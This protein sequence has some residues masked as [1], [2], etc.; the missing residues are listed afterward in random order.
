MFYAALGLCL[1]D[2]AQAPRLNCVVRTQLEQLKRMACIAGT[3]QASETAQAFPKGGCYTDAKPIWR[4]DRTH[5]LKLS[6]C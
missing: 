1:A 3:A 2:S 5:L 4:V 6:P